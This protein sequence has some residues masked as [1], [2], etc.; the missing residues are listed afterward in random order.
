MRTRQLHGVEGRRST[1]VNYQRAPYSLVNYNDTGARLWKLDYSVRYLETK[2]KAKRKTDSRRW[3][4]NTSYMYLPVGLKNL[5]FFF[6]FQCM[7]DRAG[8]KTG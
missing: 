5:A 7:I 4:R 6:P 3:S 8:K 1:C 2:R